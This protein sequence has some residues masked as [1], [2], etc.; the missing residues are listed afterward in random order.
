MLLVSQIRD[1]SPLYNEGWN[2]AVLV[3]F[4][5]SSYFLLGCSGFSCLVNECLRFS[6]ENF[7]GRSRTHFLFPKICKS[8]E[9]LASFLWFSSLDFLPSSSYF[10]HGFLIDQEQITSTTSLF[11]LSFFGSWFCKSQLPWWPWCLQ[12]FSACGLVQNC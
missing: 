4:I 9:S 12:I 2:N 11:S 7:P 8:T 5:F 3:W 10:N 1:R 6:S